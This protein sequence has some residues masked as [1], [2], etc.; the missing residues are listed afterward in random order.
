MR[1]RDA[2]V[3]QPGLRGEERPGADADDATGALGGDLYPADVSGFAPHVVDAAAAGQDQGVDR[4]ARIGQ[5]LGDQR[6]AGAGG[7]G[8]AV[9]GH[10]A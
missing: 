9:A 1:G 5:R 8:L 2:A 6:E 4:L 7:G 10:D 3:D